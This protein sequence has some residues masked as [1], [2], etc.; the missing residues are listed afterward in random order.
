ML[1]CF[2]VFVLLPALLGFYLFVEG[3]LS[4]SSLRP[5]ELVDT[6]LSNQNAQ[7]C[8]IRHPQQEYEKTS[9]YR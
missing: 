9:N 6:A 5:P 1:Y 7:D 8:L 4:L 3:L 2:F